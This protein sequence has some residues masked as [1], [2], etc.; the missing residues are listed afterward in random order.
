M[1]RLA[2]YDDLKSILAIYNIARNYM[3][4]TGNSKQWNPSYPNV[5]LLELDIH[6]KQ[7]FVMVENTEIYAVFVLAIGEDPT[8]AYIEDG[9]W[10][11]SLTYGVI[12]RVASN[13]LVKGVFQDCL[14]FCNKQCNYLRIDTHPDN[15]TMQHLIV[16]SGFQKC[17]I[18]YVADGTKRIAYDKLVSSAR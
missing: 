14:E 11:Y 6:K 10:N 2:T 4:N 3:I 18:I 13:G 7:L 12:H 1:I 16:K 17:G 8:Y 15:H 5:D 9:K